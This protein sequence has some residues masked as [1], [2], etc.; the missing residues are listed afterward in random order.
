MSQQWVTESCRNKAG[1][2]HNR[3]AL[4]P[5]IETL[6]CPRQTLGAC[7]SLAPCCVTTEE[8]LCA[9][10]TRPGAHDR[11]GLAHDKGLHAQQGDSIAID[12]S[13]N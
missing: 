5:M 11:L 13:N 2:A 10:Q 3:D 12:L 4:L 8:A 1:R 6:C 9:R 7:N